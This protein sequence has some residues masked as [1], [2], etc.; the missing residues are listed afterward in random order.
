MTN[1]TPSA[2]LRAELARAG[3]LQKDVGALLGLDQ[4]QVSSRIN[5]KVPWRV[6]ELQT[7]ARHLGVSVDA[8]I[9]DPE[10]V[11][12]DDSAVAS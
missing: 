2:N 12:A 5:G 3:L 10:P 7:I 8:L 4:P 11:A 6:T 1:P 9:D